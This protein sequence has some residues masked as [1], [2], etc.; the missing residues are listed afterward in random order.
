MFRALFYPSE[1]EVYTENVCVSVKN[2]MYGCPSPSSLFFSSSYFPA[3]VP[4]LHL[5][6]EMPGSPI[7][8][9]GPL[10]HLLASSR[11]LATKLGET[12]EG[13]QEDTSGQGKATRRTLMDR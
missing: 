6:H 5:I 2:S 7:L 12:G 11:L 8:P 3:P 13:H 1:G 9:P 4:A 10:R